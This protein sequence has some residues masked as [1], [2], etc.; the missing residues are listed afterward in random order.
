[1]PHNGRGVAQ[2]LKFTVGFF[3]V[4]APIFVG[5]AFPPAGVLL[6]FIGMGSGLANLIGDDE[7]ASGFELMNPTGIT[8]C[9][10]RWAFTN[11]GSATG[12]KS[13]GGTLSTLNTIYKFGMDSDVFTA[14]VGYVGGATGIA[15]FAYGLYSAGIADTDFSPQTIEQLRG[16]ATMTGCLEQQ[17]RAVGADL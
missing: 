4:A 2:G 7:I 17:W 1:M 16:T 11:A 14:P 6:A 10:A 15:N 12:G 3:A 9:A 13:P 5:L 8:A